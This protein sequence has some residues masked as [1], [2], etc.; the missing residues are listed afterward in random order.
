MITWPNH[1]TIWY[2]ILTNLN[3]FLEKKLHMQ[4]SPHMTRSITF[5]TWVHI[6]KGWVQSH[7]VFY[8]DC[9]S[10]Y[11]YVC[12]RI[13][14]SYNHHILCSLRSISA[15]IDENVI[16]CCVDRPCFCICIVFI[17]Y[18]CSFGQLHYFFSSKNNDCYHFQHLPNVRM[19]PRLA[20]IYWP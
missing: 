19:P 9:D 17:L 12:I 16:V 11:L 14:Y 7:L 13:R 3:D 5:S 20:P 6:F 15:Q 10:L 4:N 2:A 8:G 1:M 18:Y